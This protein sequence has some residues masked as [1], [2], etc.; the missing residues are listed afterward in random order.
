MGRLNFCNHVLQGKLHKKYLSNIKLQ[1]TR[2]LLQRM[3]VPDQEQA[4]PDQ[5]VSEAI[6]YLLEPDMDHPKTR[7]YFKPPSHPIK[8]LTK[9]PT[10]FPTTHISTNIQPEDYIKFF[11]HWKET[12]VSSPSGQH[13]GYY[14]ALFGEPD[15]IAYFCKILRMPL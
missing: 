6:D 5:W 3:K 2:E 4:H 14:K 10:K 7:K 12:T 11:K 13:I 8:R 15:I 1:E 9:P